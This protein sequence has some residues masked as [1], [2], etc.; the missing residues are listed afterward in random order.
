[1]GAGAASLFGN[2]R[3]TLAQFPNNGISPV[4]SLEMDE[5]AA[6]ME[7]GSVGGGSLCQVFDKDPNSLGGAE[8]VLPSPMNSRVIAQIPSWERSMRSKSPLSFG[9]IDE[10][11]DSMI[12]VRMAKFEKTHARAMSTIQDTN[13]PPPEENDEST[14]MEWEDSQQPR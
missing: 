13:T 1:M 4:N 12:R 9:S 5:S 2:S 10:S 14:A 7:Q 11:D 8:D 6:G 3:E